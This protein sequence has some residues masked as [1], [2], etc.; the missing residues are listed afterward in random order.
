MESLASQLEVPEVKECLTIEEMKA[1]IERLRLI[2]PFLWGFFRMANYS[3]IDWQE[4]FVM[5]SYHLLKQNADLKKKLEE[6]YLKEPIRI[7]GVSAGMIAGMMIID[8]PVIDNLPENDWGSASPS[9]FI[10]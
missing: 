4:K 1:E 10:P 5:I 7:T 9:K 8:D 2:D 6:K 3:Q